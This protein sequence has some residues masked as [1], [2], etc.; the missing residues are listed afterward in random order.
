MP[1]PSKVSQ[2]PE[3]VRLELDRRLLQNG[4]SDHVA[5]AAWLVEQGFEISK[6]SVGRH[7]QQLKER[8]AAIK[9]STE[10]ARLIVA[11]A[12]D[13]T[14]D[15]AAAVISL[16][17]THVF[18]VLLLLRDAEAEEDPTLRAVVL[19]KVARAVADLTR[20]S[21]AQKRFAEQVRAKAKEAAATAE[22]VAKKGGLSADAVNEIRASILG[23]AA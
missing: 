16:T 12:G 14:D 5:L 11:E 8:L 3:A 15:R 22:R 20:A 19:S 10:A 7:S 1:E 21:V 6:S 2:L 23:I 9:A 18:D 4:F 17:Q 13:D